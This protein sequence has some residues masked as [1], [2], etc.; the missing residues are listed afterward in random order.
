MRISAF[1]LLLFFALQSKSQNTDFKDLFL[2]DNG[3]AITQKLSKSVDLDLPQA[4]STYDKKQA[5]IILGKFFENNIP[6][7][8]TSNHK[9]GGNGR[10][11]YEIGQLRS[12]EKRYRTY[13]LYN[14]KAEKLEIIELRI[15]LEE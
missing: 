8:Y 1:L 6:T 3:N 9:G 13:L 10:A 7:S 5:S 12:G 15:E 4:K 2:K 14:N 11:N